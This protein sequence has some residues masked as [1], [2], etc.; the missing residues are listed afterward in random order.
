MLVDASETCVVVDVEISYVTYT[1]Q[2]K[3]IELSVLP[4]S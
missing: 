4:P 2:T 1:I 3:K